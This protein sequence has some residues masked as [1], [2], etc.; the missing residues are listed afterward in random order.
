M[1]YNL[2]DHVFMETPDK[3]YYTSGVFISRNRFVWVHPLRKF[4]PF[5]D[6]SMH[7]NCVLAKYKDCYFIYNHFG[8]FLA[9]SFYKVDVNVDGYI[10]TKNPEHYVLSGKDGQ[11]LYEEPNWHLLPFMGGR[12]ETPSHL[13]RETRCLNTRAGDVIIELVDGVWIRVY[14]YGI[15]IRKHGRMSYLNT[16]YFPHETLV[17][18]ASNIQ[19]HP[20]FTLSVTKKDGSYYSMKIP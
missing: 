7:V 6:V 5:Y 16:T 1:G 8:K 15:T 2:E 18:D 9:K 11:N 19:V 17:T 14:R 12:I 20:D 13:I 10:L 3:M 4:L